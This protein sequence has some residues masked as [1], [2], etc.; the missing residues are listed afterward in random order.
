MTFI[1]DGRQIAAELQFR[2]RAGLAQLDHRPNLI[3]IRVGDDPA[4]ALY[5]QR[6]AKTARDIGINAGSIHL[7][8][9]LSEATLLD[10]VKSLNADGE[11]HAILVQLPLPPH[12]DPHRIIEAIDPRKDVDG[13]HPVNMGRLWRGTPYHIPCTPKGILKLLATADVVLPGARVLMI[14]CGPIVGQP[15]AVLLARAGATVTVA[16]KLTRDLPEECLWAEVIIVAAGCP[17][18]VRG[19]FIRKNAVVIDVGINRLD[20]QIVGDVAFD[21]CLGIAR[22]ITPVPGGV[23]P[24]TVAC[25]LENTIEASRLQHRMTYCEV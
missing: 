14:G 2:L 6:K 7:P 5:V 25:L 17:N 16:H 9:D 4:S 15:L 24:M 12:I 13:F 20:G 8:S 18:L 23:G 21:E 10:I 1:I 22:A 3:V 19:S 11:V